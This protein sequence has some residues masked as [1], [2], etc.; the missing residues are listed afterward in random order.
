MVNDADFFVSHRLNL[1]IAVRQAGYRAVVSCP[2]GPTTRVFGEHG[3]EHVETVPVRRHNG[4]IG[5][6]YTLI[7]YNRVLSTIRPDL[8]HLITA[9]PVIFGGALARL[10]GIPT[11][12][13]ISGL[14]YLFTSDRPKVRLLR[15][16]VC[17]GYAFALNRSRST[18]IFQNEVDRSIFARLQL[19]RHARTVIIKGSGV[20]L[21]RITV[22]AEPAGPPVVL[23]PARL[24]RDKGVE[25][26]AQ[27]AR[28][29]KAQ[30][31]SVVFRLQGKLDPE[32]PTGLSADEL[33]RW[34]NEGWVEHI[35]YST[36]VDRMFA[37]VNLVALPSYREGFP[38]SL[39]DAAAAGRA[40]VTTDV[41]G[42]RDA[43]RPGLSGS[44]VPVRDV[45]ALAA[46]ILDLI[47]DPI[48][49]AVMGKE[50]RRLAEAEF[51]IK[52]VTEQ[53]LELYVQAL[54]PRA[55]A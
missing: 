16:L 13:A 24:L 29:V 10:R 39:V 21:S 36:D 33:A 11:V 45:A 1:A 6:L 51:D 46:A 4:L 12:S 35:P 30:H 20:D 14:G 44:L 49:R 8:I 27:A 50:G 5:Q 38:K 28:Q 52:R 15:A 7:S 42:C 54:L 55:H 18:V 32:N 2:P 17:R 31:P 40:V 9:K 26:F 41:P 25:E 22:H 48:R 3:I 37:D 19:T 43:I 53:H 47:G 23:L 34:I